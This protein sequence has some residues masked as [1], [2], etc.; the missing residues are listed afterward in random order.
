M[1]EVS[2]RPPRTIWVGFVLIF[3]ACALAFLL[4]FVQAARQAAR[5]LR[6][7]GQVAD[8]T[9]T[10]QD[11]QVTTLANLTNH[12]WVADIIFTRCAGQCPR[13]TAQMK[14]LQD[15]LPKDSTAKL[16]TL[17]TDPD[18]DTPAVLKRYGEH[19][20]ADFHRWLFL[21]G[22]KAQIGR[23]GANSLK[24]SAQPVQP[25]DQKSADDLFIH[26]TVFV[27]VDKHAQV[28]G[29]FETGGDNVDWVNGVRPK[30][31]SALHQLEAE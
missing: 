26:A 28:R 12:V 7:L 18:Y 14:S 8:F 23:L 29:F 22:T 2:P 21:T 13:M 15:L 25:Q 31:L 11:G 9:L 16:V 10:N 17:T 4:W 1:N 30:L 3:A 19:Y 27:L 20:G 6:V 24:L 5:P